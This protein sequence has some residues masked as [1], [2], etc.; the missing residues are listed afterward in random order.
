[1]KIMRICYFHLLGSYCK[2]MKVSLVYSGNR[3][4]KKDNQMLVLI[5]LAGIQALESKRKMYMI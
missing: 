3:K 1:M 4:T 2:E 5:M